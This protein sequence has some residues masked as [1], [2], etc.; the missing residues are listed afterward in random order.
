MSN[1][2]DLSIIPTILKKFKVKNII[3]SGI[4]DNKVLNQI[5]YHCDN[6]NASFT[7][8]DSE[9][10]Y[11]GKF[12]ENILNILNNY[13]NYDAIFINDDPNW[14]T[15]YN[16][17][18]IIKE[19]NENFPLVFICNN[20]FPNKKRD[21]YINPNIIP[22]EYLNEYSKYLHLNDKVRIHDNLYHAKKEFTPKNGVLT[23]IEDFLK[24]NNN[25]GIMDIKLLNGITILYPL[26]SIS[27]IRLSALSEEMENYSLEINNLSDNI[28]ENQILSDYIAKF[29]SS[30]N[31]MNL[32]D[33]YKTKLDEKENLINKYEDEIKL[34]ED[35]LSYKDSQ[36][37]RVD[38]KL[39]FKDSQIKNVESKLVNRENEINNLNNKLNEAD[40]KINRLSTE[41]ENKEKILKKMENDFNKKESTLNNELK[42]VK[43]QIKFNKEILNDNN[44]NI[45]FKDNQI[46][47]KQK[48]LDKTKNTLNLI[49]RQYH[50]QLSQLDT[51]RYCITCYKEE[52]KN[53][54]A[55]IEYLKRNS[56][57]KKIL[58]PI[59]YLYILIKSNP[60]EWSVNF[61]LYKQLKKSKCFDIGYYL[62]NNTDILESKW[63]KYF[64]PELHY[65]CNGFK[66]GRRFNKKY[67]SR[68][69]KKK[70]LDNLSRYDS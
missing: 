37:K 52:I 68:Q 70:L 19:T 28:I 36:I 18:N 64:S 38:S 27:Q 25:I 67:Y 7:S 23:A 63:S 46:K 66:E 13:N 69:S 41:I 49:K 9:V 45:N 20:V 51:E 4:H 32:I 42:D 47:Y 21:S 43:N 39:S 26:N 60:K 15:V 56:L 6:F 34:H 59:G 1:F 62:N 58:S 55:E 40:N 53:N 22:D 29:N 33:D 8:I 35:E 11:E 3:L 17:L 61:K 14:F 24:E 50:K 44:L 31:N 57:I 12:E 2:Y 5:V 10:S 16:E 30:E 65:I 48:E 54:Q